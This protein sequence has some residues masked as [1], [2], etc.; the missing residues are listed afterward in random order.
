MRRQS[1]ASIGS[2]FFIAG[3]SLNGITAVSAGIGVSPE[4]VQR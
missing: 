1:L 4:P 3:S 2:E